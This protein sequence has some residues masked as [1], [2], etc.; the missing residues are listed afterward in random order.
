MA[1]ITT[2]TQTLCPN[3]S[4]CYRVQ[5]AASDRQYDMAFPYTVSVWGVECD[6]YV[7]MRRI[8]VTNTTNTQDLTCKTT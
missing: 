3:A 5:V 4:H 6:Y 8:D 1:D 7:P 2:C